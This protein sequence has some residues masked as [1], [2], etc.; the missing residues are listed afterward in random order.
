M[1][2]ASN[3]GHDEFYRFRYGEA[4]DQTGDEYQ[5]CQE[6]Y[7]Q[8]NVVLRYAG[9][10]ERVV[11]LIV[12]FATAAAENDM[13]G[14]D[15][16]ERETFWYALEEC[17]YN[18]ANIYYPCET[19]C[20][21]STES[22]IKAVGMYLGIQE[23]ASIPIDVYTGNIRYVLEQAG[24][25]AI[26]DD[27]MLINGYGLLPGDIVLNESDDGHV[28]IVV[29]NDDQDTFEIDGLWGRYT[30]KAIQRYI[31]TP[32]DGEVSHQHPE[33]AQPGFTTGW[34][35][36]NTYEGSEMIRAIQEWL[37]S[38]GLYDAHIDG[39]CGTQTIK[40]L[41][42]MCGTTVDGIISAPSDC[43][44]VMQERLVDGTLF[45]E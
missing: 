11:P 27:D 4:G 15:M 35:Y 13:I 43:V 12:D 22:I 34:Q 17:G 1:I 25:V 3:C 18:P 41:Q 14:Y 36:D 8:Q 9:S 5:I 39:L 40:G 28:N 32:I 2:L 33:C 23:L 45:K 21:I 38:R 19:D 20:S 37:H 16:S 44:K 29:S 42:R 7:F 30:T 31:G 10:D 6:Y 26:Y 24:F